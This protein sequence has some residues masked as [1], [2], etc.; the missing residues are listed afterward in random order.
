MKRT[1]LLGAPIAILSAGCGGSSGSSPSPAASAV[2]ANATNASLEAIDCKRERAYVPIAPSGVTDAEVAVL[3]L[4]VDPATTDPRIATI[5]LGHGGVA[6]GAAIA[7]KQ[8]LAL[9]ISGSA[10][11]AGFLDQINE[12]DN[13]LVTGSP[14]SFPPGGQPLTS[15]G[16]VFDSLNNNALVSMTSTPLTCPGGSTTACTGMATFNLATNSFGTLIQFD[17]SVA[18]FGFDPSAQI[19]L[20]LSDPVDPIPYAI[21]ANGNAACTLTDESLTSL[22]GDPEGAAADP[23]TGIWVVGNF[24][25]VLTS[26]IN[27][28]GATF[29][30]TPPSCTLQEAGTPPSNSLNFDTRAN[31]F[32][33][34]VSINPVTHQ[35][36]LTGKLD[37]QIA[38]VS[39][40]KTRSKFISLFDLSAVNTSLPLE[41]DGVQFQAAIL[42]YSDSIDTCHNRAYIVNA[43]ETFLAEVDLD[44]FQDAPN[45]IRTALPAGT[46]AGTST[47]LSCD[48]LNGVRFFPLPG[49]L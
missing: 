33:T 4:S 21:N 42:P 27:L 44:K 24:S 41:P 32:L 25:N 22:N 40:P 38:L 11:G 7:P 17:T 29:S 3:D 13:S 35:A 39:L 8:G 28:S 45:A 46:C 23:S 34:G 6:R 36:V 12:S 37:N 15:D 30:G 47:R 10:A 16:I 5:D 19:A 26:V 20:G 43:A 9:I 18:N 1:W 48:N 14:F 31:D 2:F 49:V